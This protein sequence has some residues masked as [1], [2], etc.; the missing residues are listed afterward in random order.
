MTERV[1]NLLHRIPGYS[2]YRD[3]ERRR[4]ED[5]QIREETARD[6]TIVVDRLTA[7]NAALVAQRNLK[8]VSAIEQ[9]VSKTRQLA[10]RIRTASYGYAGLFSDRP[11]EEAALDQLQRFDR[12]IAAQVDKLAA[13]SAT[14]ST[15]PEGATTISGEVDR[16][17][18]LFDGRRSVI[19][20]AVPTREKQVLDLLDTSEPAKPSPI[21]GVRRGFAF[22]VLGDNFQATATVTLTDGDLTIQFVRVGDTEGD[23]AIW[24]VGATRSDV[25]SA[26][27]VESSTPP[28]NITPLPL[29]AVQARV[30]STRGTQDKLSAGYAF[31]PDTAMGTVTFLLELAGVTRYYTGSPINDFDVEVYGSGT[32]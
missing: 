1:T 21:V 7:A 18:L 19:E 11:I 23:A 25:P 26:R 14:L 28:E 20:T 6:L 8:N 13:D 30:D 10:D 29:K 24:F 16:L 2:G 31:T 4:D 3:K 17:A 5:R 9:V 22:S 12:T 27:L 32:N 15:T